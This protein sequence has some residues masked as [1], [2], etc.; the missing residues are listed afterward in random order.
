MKHSIEF[1]YDGC[2]A[3]A[4][5]GESIV[6]PGT[7]QSYIGREAFFEALKHGNSFRVILTVKIEPIKT[8]ES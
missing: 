4:I 3:W 6:G 2:E 8:K 5:N 1:I 7:V